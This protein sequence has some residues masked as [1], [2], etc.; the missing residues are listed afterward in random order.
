MALRLPSASTAVVASIATALAVTD[1]NSRLLWL[2]KR[3]FLLLLVAN[4]RALPFYWHI[5]FYGLIPKLYWRIWT[6]GEA[7]AMSIGKD[8]YE[9][10]TITKGKVS[11]AESDYNIHMSNSSYAK[12]LDSARFAWL[13]ELIGPAFGAGIWSPL[14]STSFTF[15][16]EIPYGA[17]YEIDVH[18]VSY[19]DKWIYY[20]AR[21]TT[22]PHKGTTERTLNC[23]AFSRSCFKLRGSRL[24]IPP[25]RVLSA[26]GC[27][28]DR[29][30]WERWLK[31]RKEKKIRKWLEYGGALVARK[32]GKLT[33]GEFPAGEEGWEV[34]GMEALEH[35]R[36]KGLP[37]AQRFGDTTGWEDL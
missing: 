6:K 19:D 31:L 28:P 30:N 37:V 26:S 15:F 22:A 29:S 24:T 9:V 32:N 25:A 10:R 1:S 35:K 3:G 20:V 36:L 5:D 34:D 2:A 4:W 12:V 16:K 14:A 18:L 33:N 27:G 17:K 13:L 11:W 21:F 23:I 7:K 8:P